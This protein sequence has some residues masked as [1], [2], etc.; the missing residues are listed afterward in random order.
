MSLPQL[1]P[2]QSG[3]PDSRVVQLWERRHLFTLLAAEVKHLHV[4]RS[5]AKKEKLQDFYN[6]NGCFIYFAHSVCVY[7]CAGVIK[8]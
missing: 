6:K 4:T 7:V 5:K 8:L 3:D 2:C 1:S